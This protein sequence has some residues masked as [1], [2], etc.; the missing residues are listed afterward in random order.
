MGTV[1]K[2]ALDQNINKTCVVYVKFDDSQAVVKAIEKCTDNYAG[3]NSA[4]PIQLV[5]ARITVRSGKQSS[6]E[7]QRLQ[8]PIT[9]A[10]TSTVHKV[11]GLTL[12][13]VVVSAM[14]CWKTDW[15][16]NYFSLSCDGNTL[17]VTHI[18]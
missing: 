14:L 17:L 3:E 10:W 5:L 8:F 1:T 18:N 13:E 15:W 2:I 12:N 11:L 9:L 16:N 6:P 7:L 4:V